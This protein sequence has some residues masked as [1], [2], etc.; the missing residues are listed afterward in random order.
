MQNGGS[1]L[2]RGFFWRVRYVFRN[3]R[4]RNGRAGVRN[5]WWVKGNVRK[6]TEGRKG[7]AGPFLIAVIGALRSFAKPWHTFAILLPA[8]LVATQHFR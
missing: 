4:V 3:A 6:R 5:V 8:A 1:L 7:H 2:G